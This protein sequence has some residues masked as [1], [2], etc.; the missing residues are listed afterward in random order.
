MKNLHAIIGILWYD[1][2]LSY[3]NY[4]FSLFCII[5]A[6]RQSLLHKNLP[7]GHTW[8]EKLNLLTKIHKL[9]YIQGLLFKF[10]QLIFLQQA[11][12]R[13][14]VREKVFLFGEGH[15]LQKP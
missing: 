2:L 13:K 4:N 6:T 15:I 1:Y 11:F 10:P 7:N 12:S 5:S 9:L 8:L 14:K 3:Y